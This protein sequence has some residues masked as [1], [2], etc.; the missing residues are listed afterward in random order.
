MDPDKPVLLVIFGAGASFDSANT[1][2][3][4][5][6]AGE[7]QVP[8]FGVLPPP[9]A[10]DIVSHQ[11]DDIA[12]RTT[13]SRPVIDRLRRRMGSDTT[14]SLETE[15]ARLYEKPGASPNRRQQLVTFRFYL[16]QVI[17]RTLR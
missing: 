4:Y 2:V 5:V 6:P 17:M 14:A 16:L 13:G 7:R 1:D 10:K 11:F 15:L 12:A 8:G 3:R 9:L